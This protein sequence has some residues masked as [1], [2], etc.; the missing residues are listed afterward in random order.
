MDTYRIFHYKIHLNEKNRI[1]RNK[2]WNKS[3]LLW[4]FL[5]VYLSV[6]TYIVVLLWLSMNGEY[7]CVCLDILRTCCECDLFYLVVE[8]DR[9]RIAR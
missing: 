9:E 2:N 1:K 4:I 8:S 6:C 7:V 3:D 5:S